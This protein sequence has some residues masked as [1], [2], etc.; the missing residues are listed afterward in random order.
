MWSSSVRAALAAGI[1]VGLAAST[2]A[3][4]LNWASSYD[5]AQK[6]AEEKDTLIMVDF[7]TDW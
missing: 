5:E 7:Y 4:G 6:I 1:V 2:A 3:A